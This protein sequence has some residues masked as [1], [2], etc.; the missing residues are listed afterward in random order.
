MIRLEDAGINTAD[1]VT[2]ISNLSPSY[3]FESENISNVSRTII[4]SSHRTIPIVSKDNNL[5]GVVT[6][7]DILDALL[8]GSTQNT[9]VSNFMTRK[10]VTCDVSESMMTAMQKIRYSKRG[11]LPVVKNNKLIGMV[12]ERDVLNLFSN[13][14]FAKTVGNSMTHKPF[15]T[16]H[17][18]TIDACMKAMVN[19]HYR[20]FPVLEN[21]ELVGIVT[22]GD[23]LHFL[24]NNNFNT[25]KMHQPVSEIM[26]TPVKYTMEHAD[27]SEAIKIMVDGKISGLPVVN[28][29]NGLVGII[30][31]R[32]IVEISS[33]D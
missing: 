9:Q 7:M 17:S 3:V 21:R 1:S 24:V 16:Q 12:G 32:N 4:N 14:Y 23:I 6:Y 20:R 30:T 11:N 33:L 18:A 26:S 29:N 27:L 19:T 8:K 25:I 10:V 15:F 2:H 28:E 5:L 31:E 22:G 13:K